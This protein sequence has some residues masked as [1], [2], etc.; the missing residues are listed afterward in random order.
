MIRKIRKALFPERRRGR[1]L[2]NSDL[3]EQHR[4]DVFVLMHQQVGGLR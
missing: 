4:D 3:L 1:R 2:F